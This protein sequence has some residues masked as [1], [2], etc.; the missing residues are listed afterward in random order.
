VRSERQ[1]LLPEGFLDLP[2]ISGLAAEGGAMDLNKCREPLGVVPS[3]VAV[4]FLVCVETEKLAYDLDGEDFGVGK[5]RGGAALTDTPS[6]EL[7]VYQAEDGHNEGAKIHG[8]RPPLRRLVWLLPSV[9]RS[10]LSF[11]LSRK[12]AHG[13]S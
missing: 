6:F 13:V 3:K 1:K 10:S 8:R 2:E 9:R 7:I 4:E 5:L 11:K 12:L